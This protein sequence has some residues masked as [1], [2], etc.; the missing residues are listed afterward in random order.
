MTSRRA[1][2]LTAPPGMSRMTT[3]PLHDL[4][5]PYMATVCNLACHLACNLARDLASTRETRPGLARPG[6]MR[7]G[8][9][10]SC[11]SCPSCRSG[12]WR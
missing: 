1:C 9:A 3:Q 11:R 10:E 7:P 6:W 8:L 5:A 4:Q 12:P 2:W